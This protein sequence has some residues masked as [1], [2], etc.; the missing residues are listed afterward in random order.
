MKNLKLFED[1]FKTEDYYF[2]IDESDYNYIPL[3]G[4]FV[5]FDINLQNQLLSLY[6]LDVRQVHLGYQN[7]ESINGVEVDCHGFIS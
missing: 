6:K 3:T 4:L 2:S 1:F 5:D 7:G